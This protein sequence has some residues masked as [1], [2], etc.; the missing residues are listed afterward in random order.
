[1]LQLRFALLIGM[2]LGL[3]LILAGIITP[4]DLSIRIFFIIIGVLI[5][6]GVGK[7]VKNLEK[8][9]WG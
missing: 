8:F 7:G 2:M 5:L 6:I 9:K 3:I 1:M 4:I